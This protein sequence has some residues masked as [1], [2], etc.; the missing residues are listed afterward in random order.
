MENL[1][2]FFNQNTNYAIGWTVIHSLWQATAIALLSGVAMLVLRKKTAQT[3]YVVHNIALC[4]VLLAAV[5]TF[6][7]YM[8]GEGNHSFVAEQR[9]D[10]QNVSEA[11]NSFSIGVN[12]TKLTVEQTST[13]Q[14]ATNTPL[15][16]LSGS[17]ISIEAMKTYFDTHIYLIVSIWLMGVC[18]FLLKLM[19]NISYV[20]YLRRQHNFPVDEYWFDM[21]QDLLKKVNIKKSI[22][23]VESALVRSPVVVGYLKPMILFPIGAIN[24]LNPQE[25]EAILAHEIAHIMRHDYVFNIIQSIIEALFYFNP[26]VWWISAN[27]RA[28]RENC[29]DDIAIQ[30]CGNSMTYAKSLV[31]VQ[32]MQYYSA[33]FAMGFAGQRKNQ[34]L[35]RV[36]RVLNQSSSKTNVMEK[37]FATSLIIISLI[38]LGYTQQNNNQKTPNTNTVVTWGTYTSPTEEVTTQSNLKTLNSLAPLTSDTTKPRF[39]SPLPTT[40]EIEELKQELAEME[41]KMPAF[42]QKKEAEIARLEKELAEMEAKMPEFEKKTQEE[43]K[44]VEQDVAKR[45]S[46]GP[47]VKKGNQERIAKIEKEIAEKEAELIDFEKEAKAKNAKL[48]VKIDEKKKLRAS[49]SGSDL[50]ALNGDIQGLMGEMQGNIG[51]IA[52]L[53]G[54]IAGLRGEIGGIMGEEGGY[55]GEIGGKRGEIGGKHGEIAGKRG[56]IAGKQGE[57]QGKRGEMMGKHGEIQGKAGEIQGKIAEQIYQTLVNDLKS[58]NIITSEKKLI[59]R[60]NATA[61]YVNDVKQSDALF[62]KYKAKYIKTP[63][64]NIYIMKSNN[65]RNISIGDEDDK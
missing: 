23:L 61:F 48:Q 62:A 9:A 58:D 20:Y 65:N 44:A 7:F 26:A 31:L 32:E 38:V 21:I 6:N 49:K 14:I 3:R 2:S 46:K 55:W 17:S 64:F 18:L 27:I 33:A 4:L 37:L 45:E 41:A 24:R 28:E 11:N 63:S 43:I 13:T 19:G 22:D 52:G 1:L 40:A 10:N 8:K 30:L 12:D 57:I 34:L 59:V 42:E 47:S 16:I 56:E 36:Q 60:L 35:L 53:R 29:C 39:F 51:E 54:E 25:V 5:V 15:P 50:M